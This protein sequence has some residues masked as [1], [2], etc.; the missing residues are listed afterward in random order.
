MRVPSH[1]VLLFA[2][3]FFCFLCSVSQCKGVTSQ[4]HD[5]GP[6]LH[7]RESRTL[8][9]D[10]D[11]LSKMNTP[12]QIIPESI[13]VNSTNASATDSIMLDDEFMDVSVGKW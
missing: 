9:L 10:D 8:V 2:I 13:N 11:T 12:T 7:R 4:P 6:K 1:N 3:L 5:D